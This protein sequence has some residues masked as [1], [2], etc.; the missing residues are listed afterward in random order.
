MTTDW[1]GVQGALCSHPKNGV[2]PSAAPAAKSRQCGQCAVESECSCPAT[3][4]V[5]AV[6]CFAEACVAEACVAEACVAEACVAEA[7]CVC[8]V[9][10]LCVCEAPCES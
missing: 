1:R 5:A 9:P 7:S 8:P 3:A 10:A 2:V 6:S 4:C